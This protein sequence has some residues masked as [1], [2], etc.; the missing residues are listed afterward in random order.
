MKHVKL[1]DEAARRLA[2]EI[3]ARGRDIEEFVNTA[4]M[5]E[6]GREAFEIEEI[7]K[8]L[9]EADAGNFASEEEVEAVFSKYALD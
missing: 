6:L 5:R 4:V 3:G 1:S 7:R 2:A 9:A 8:G